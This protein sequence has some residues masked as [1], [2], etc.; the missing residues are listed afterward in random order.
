MKNL[1]ALLARLKT[2]SL[3]S[4]ATK[5]SHLTQDTLVAAV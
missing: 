1:A 5:E 3:Q 4:F 2:L